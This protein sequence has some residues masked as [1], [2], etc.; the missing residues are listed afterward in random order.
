VLSQLSTLALFVERKKSVK[1]H[2]SVIDN[3]KQW[4]LHSV[5]LIALSVSVGILDFLGIRK[6]Y[7]E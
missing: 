2:I 5:G 6:P 3:N 4:A 1:L 7:R